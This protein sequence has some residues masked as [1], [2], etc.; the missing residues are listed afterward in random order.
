MYDD[1][2]LIYY[3]DPRL[4]KMSQPVPADQFGPNLKA[5]VERL[6]VV[7]REHKGVGLAAPQVGLNLRVFVINPTGE[8]DADRA[9]VNPVL[10]DPD[11]EDDAE[12]GC[13]SLPDI[14]VDVVRDIRM[15]I[16]AQDVDGNTFIER[17]DGFIA[18]IWQHEYDHL[19]GTLLTNRMGPVAKIAARRKLKELEDKYQLV[20]KTR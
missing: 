8:P 1:L 5:L 9:Y 2:K 4:K 19:N 12:E 18:R 20:K 6:F 3:P 16:T 11:G 14:H 13:L 10:S 7:M 17:A 15:T